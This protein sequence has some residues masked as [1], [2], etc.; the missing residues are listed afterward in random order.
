M[1]LEDSCWKAQ[2]ELSEK[3]NAIPAQQSN[4]ENKKGLPRKGQPTKSS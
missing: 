1:A 2:I 3:V 4:A